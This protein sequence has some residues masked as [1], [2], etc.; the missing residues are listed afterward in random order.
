MA[1]H[2]GRMSW[3]LFFL[4]FL[5]MDGGSQ[6]SANKRPQFNMDPIL[7][8]ED[9]DVGTVVF[10]INATDEENDPLTYGLEGPDSYYFSCNSS[11]GEVTL[12][13]P[14][15]YEVKKT[16]D[17][18]LTVRDQQDPP[19]T[20]ITRIIVM[21][22]NDNYPVF[23][24]MPYRVEVKEN[25][26]LGFLIIQV[27]AEDYDFDRSLPVTITIEEVIPSSSDLFS[28]NSSG[29]PAIG[30]ITLNGALNYNSKSS[31]YQIKL[32]AEDQGFDLV[33]N[34][35]A[36]VFV[37]V[38]DVPDLDP[39]FIGAPYVTSVY[40]N[41][42]LGEVVLRVYATDPDRGINDEIQYSIYSSSVSG[43]FNISLIE[44]EI[45]VTG[46]IDREALLDNDEQVILTVRATEKQINVNGE[47]A[48]TPTNVTIR[49][50]DINDNKPQFYK[51]EVT[52]CNFKDDPAE[53]FTG[54]IEEHSSVRVPVANLTITANDP[55]KDQN[56]AFNLYLRGHD[57]DCFT[58][59]PQRVINTGL[60][61]ILVK[62]SVAIDY[63]LVHVMHVEVVANDT[64]N[65]QDCCSVVSVT[66]NLIDIN[67]HSP[68][69]LHT[70]YVL[71]IEEHSPNGT[72]LGIITA[73]DP[74]SE[75]YGKIT[76]S[77]LPESI[78]DSFQVH[79]STGE[80][81]VVNGELLDRERRSS[82]YATL[83]AQ[84]GMN[85]TGTT[86]LEI[87]LLDINDWP[88]EAI[89]TYNIFVNE[90]TDDVYIPLQA[91]DNDEPGTNNSVIEFELL[92]RD[93]N[94]NFSINVTTGLIT[95]L[96]PLDREAIDITLNGRIVLTTRL[97]DLGVP[98]LSSTVNVTI[99]VEDLNDNE[100]IFSQ[101]E[102]HF[103][104]NESTKGVYVGSL[105][106]S[107]HD[108][109]E[110]NNRVSF[111]ISQGGLGNFII[112]GQ[113]EALGQYLGV[114]ALDPDV[115]LDYEIQKS[116]TLIIEAQDNGLQGVSNTAS[117]TAFV[118]VLDLNDEPPYIDPSSL[119][120]LYVVENRT[121]GPEW[122]V[123]LTATDP[124]I[125]HDLEFQQLSM[126]CFKDGN[127][128]GS[129]CYDWLWLAPDGQLFVNHT[130]DVDFE[131]CDL[132]VMLLR[133]ED[134]LTFLGNRYSMNVSQ[135]VVI[136]D[137][138]DHAPEF[139]E[140]TDAFVV[141][142][143][144]AVISTEVASVKAQDKDSGQN[145]VITFSIDKVE[146]VLSSGGIQQLGNIFSI[147]TLPENNIYM[148]S[149]RVASNLDK[150]LKGQYQV[151]V[152][153]MDKGTPPLHAT[154]SIKI[155]TID[156]SYRVTLYFTKS[157]E[158][159]TQ[160]SPRI[161][162]ELMKATDASVFVAGL[163]A[164][165]STKKT[166]ARASDRSVLSVYCLY[167]NGTAIA[168]EDLASIIQSNEEVLAVL[169]SLGL[170]VI[171]NPNGPGL[172]NPNDKL[173]GI[174]AG[175]AGALL[176]FIIVMIISLCCMKKSH[177]RKLRAVKASKVAK[178]LP[179]EVHEVEAIP[180]TNKFNSDRTNP[181]LNVDLGFDDM[182]STTDTASV[183][184]D[185]N[186]ILGMMDDDSALNQNTTASP[187][188]DGKNVEEPLAAALND[189]QKLSSTA[190]A[191]DTT[192]L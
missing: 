156:E 124:D 123:T 87:I 60:V 63:E 191:L 27:E 59:S 34:T 6:V 72:V 58:V 95:S 180:G 115:E 56:G 154:R 140:I 174:I 89:G 188:K 62:N 30:N 121:G 32:L 128:V 181:M 71:E 104:V 66:I 158:E 149:I 138:N 118:Q 151:S 25:E 139:L 70:T 126:Q 79:P 136:L 170:Y 64:G 111:R 2:A 76:Y 177:Q 102:Y 12:I 110:I 57:A 47:F 15:D 38:L 7:I 77:L 86:L 55:D 176:L 133:V 116:Y 3:L 99:N 192:E 172:V 150:T 157:V 161:I 127:D 40:E 21:D 24:H 8:P 125:I 108:Q 48:Y 31:F 35:T 14:L 190:T 144:T 85:A 68:E 183:N 44:G 61:Q 22:C 131:I 54:E 78:Q 168:P 134:K 13:I 182:S 163:E 93:F 152:L 4:P 189:R 166:N 1:S 187:S 67:D 112:R 101:H 51:C 119:T 171:A 100:P 120:D 90:N 179:G 142:P 175:L 42:T 148:G 20:R 92:P 103:A 43:L 122:I 36:Y 9:R 73:T 145:A 105:D 129:I 109:T 185:Y 160:N 11:S 141:I 19:T 132:M 81:T 46:H 169:L 173:Y 23:N 167:T 26:T 16:L 65:L 178:A 69:F 147:S 82:Y 162:G 18:I 114:L 94:G 39:Q 33:L 98:S 159:L 29:V 88:P 137:L 117:A 10:K 155:F 165:G 80:I 186:N 41:T 96:D 37:N 75:D 146:F 164:E 53:N 50:L 130:E 28:I 97:Y 74:D 45:N 135:R 52:D 143:E 84:D 17:V 153:A 91:F 107:D 184:S 49:I 5:L 83:R 106:V 113:K